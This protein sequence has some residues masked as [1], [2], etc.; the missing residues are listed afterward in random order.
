M[1]S[2]TLAIA[3]A[4]ALLLI[5]SIAHCEV[6]VVDGDTFDLDGVRIRVHGIDAPEYGQRCGSWNCGVEALEELQNLITSGP[7]F[8]QSISND[9]YGRVIGKCNVYGVDIG[10]E[11]VSMGLAYAFFKYSS[12]Y[13][14]EE[15]SARSG[16]LGVWSGDF[17][18]P[19]DYRAEKWL[20][21]EQE[22]PSGCPIKGNIS[23]NGQ[24]YHAPWSPWYKKTRI[25]EVKGERWFCSEAD[26][27]AA[28]WRAPSWR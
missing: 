25:N 20:S 8:C 18:R 28:G 15:D 23:E 6:T 21:A 1:K 14:N 12:D 11:M 3:S 26:A 17:Q 19:W 22:A 10:A 4:L 13:K 9:A 5:T 16:S 7:V 24:I 2:S 27:V